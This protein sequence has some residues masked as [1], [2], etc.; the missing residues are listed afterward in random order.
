MLKSTKPVISICA[1]RTGAGKSQTSRAIGEI[2]RKHNKKIVAV[3]HAMPYNRDLMKQVVERFANLSDLK[4][5]ETTLEEDEEYVPWIKKQIPVYAGIDYEKI[6]R[7]SEREADIIIFDG[8]NNDWP[9]IRPNLQIVIA[10]PLR[11][12]HEISYYPGF[13]NFLMADIILINKIDSASK[14]S[15]QIVENNIKKYNPKAIVIKARSEIIADNPKLIS[16]KRVLLIEDGPS[17]THGGMKFGAATVAAKKYGA[18][19][20]IN[21]KKY[22]VGSIRETYAKYIH[23]EK[24]LPAMGYNEKQI[25][26]LQKTI[27]RAD[28]DIVLDGSPANLKKILKVNKPIINI[29]YELDKNSVKELEKSLKRKRFI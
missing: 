9:F 20:I 18:K 3:R 1:V 6:S 19:E 14:E 2:L 26:D 7:Q 11:A 17:I 24:E 13:V 28:C 12:G 5:Y 10:D 25:K 15:I 29:S 16:G 27:N 23:L 4:K 8:G 21:A 22:A